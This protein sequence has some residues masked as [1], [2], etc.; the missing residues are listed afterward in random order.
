MA[1]ITKI[2][3]SSVKGSALTGEEYD[4]NWSLLGGG[5]TPT[6]VV[7]AAGIVTVTGAGWFLIDTEAAG[8]S[9]DVHTVQGLSIGEVVRFSSVSAARTIRF[10]HHSGS[11]NLR[12]NPPEFTCNSICDHITFQNV[13]GTLIRELGRLSVPDT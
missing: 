6:T 5:L 9:D 4:G 13:N 12:M 8:A 3:L 7:I 1:I 2:L 11:G 10:V